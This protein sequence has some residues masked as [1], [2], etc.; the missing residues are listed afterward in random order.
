MGIA[1][2]KGKKKSIAMNECMFEQPQ[3]TTYPP[4]KHLKATLLFRIKQESI[5]KLQKAKNLLE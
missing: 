5:S 4:K 2:E 1:G 3:I